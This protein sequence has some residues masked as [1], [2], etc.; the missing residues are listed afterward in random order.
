MAEIRVRRDDAGRIIPRC[1]ECPRPYPDMQF[2]EETPAY[3]IWRCPACGLVAQIRK[4]EPAAHAL[5]VDEFSTL[6]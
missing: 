4:P 5:I 2:S 1:G 6:N 3:D